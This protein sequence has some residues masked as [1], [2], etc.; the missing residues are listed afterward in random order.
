MQGQ[1]VLS[2][3]STKKNP[4]PSGEELD[5]IIPA[6]SESEMYDCMASLS[7][8]DRLYNRLVGKGAPGSKSMEQS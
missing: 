5:R 7:G 1:S 2:F 4:A 8:L 3:L 6:A